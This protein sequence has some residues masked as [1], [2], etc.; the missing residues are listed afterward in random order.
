M[1]DLSGMWLGTYWQQGIPTR[2]EI[3]LLQGGNV[4]SGRILDDSNLGEAY[5]AG[6]VVGRKVNF[7]KRYLMRSQH[8]ILYTGT[9]SAEGDFMQGQWK[10]DWFETGNWEAHRK[11]DNLV[12]EQQ[13]RTQQDIIV[14]F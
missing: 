12:F 11:G 9:V 7:M 8:V 2:F 1:A 6:E 13:N 14:P 5:L 10:M 3:S 4:L